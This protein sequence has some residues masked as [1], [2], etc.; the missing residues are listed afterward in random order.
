MLYRSLPAPLGRA[1]TS[2]G[3]EGT[4]APPQRAATAQW[5]A[6]GSS[7]R[8]ISPRPTFL[9]GPEQPSASTVLP[10][11]LSFL[12]QRAERFGFD[13]TGALRRRR[14]AVEALHAGGVEVSGLGSTMSGE[15]DDA[16]QAL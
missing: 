10:P 15:G 4:Y 6:G 14:E 9:D 8:D 1:P 3:R 11:R 7:D 13:P 16:S 5:R 12:E 2:D